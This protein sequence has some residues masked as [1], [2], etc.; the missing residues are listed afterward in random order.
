MCS[1]FPRYLQ[2]ALAAYEQARIDGLCH[3][4]AWECAWLAVRADGGDVPTAVVDDPDQLLTD[5][6]PLIQQRMTR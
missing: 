5:L 2:V 3:E 6:W 1:E 4:G